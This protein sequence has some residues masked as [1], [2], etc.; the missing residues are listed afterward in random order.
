MSKGQV[1]DYRRRGLQTSRE[2]VLVHVK[3]WTRKHPGMINIEFKLLILPQ[4]PESCRKDRGQGIDVR[5][6]I[7]SGVGSRSGQNLTDRSIMSA[8]G[9]HTTADQGFDN[10]CVEDFTMPHS[11]DTHEIVTVI[12]G[13]SSVSRSTV[14]IANVSVVAILGHPQPSPALPDDSESPGGRGFGFTRPHTLLARQVAV[15]QC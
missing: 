13:C 10:N 14:V 9:R 5:G 15:F 12:P 6:Q 8:A 4:V 7:S 1:D 2:I 11:Q 3:V